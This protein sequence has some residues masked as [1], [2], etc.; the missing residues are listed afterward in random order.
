MYSSRI[1]YSENC[2]TYEIFPILALTRS[3]KAEH[4]ISLRNEKY[5]LVQG[6]VKNICAGE[7]RYCSRSQAAVYRNTL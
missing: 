4:E 3:Q 2:R 1:Y 7:M 6:S 5:L